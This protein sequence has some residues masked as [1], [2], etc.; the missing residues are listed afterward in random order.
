MEDN[1][2]LKVFVSYCHKDSKYLDDFIKHVRPLCDKKYIELWY[3][4]NIKAGEKFQEKI[5]SNSKNADIVVLLVSVNFLSSNACLIEKKAAIKDDKTI[6]PIIISSCAWKDDDD[7]LKLLAIPKDGKPITE[8]KNKDQGWQ[9]VYQ[10]F[11]EIIELHYEIKQIK[12]SNSFIK[13]LNNTELFSQAHSSKTEIFVSDIFVEPLLIKYDTTKNGNEKIDNI[14]KLVRELIDNKQIIITGDGQSGKTTI[15]KMLFNIL[16]EKNLIPLFIID[17]E[18]QYNGLITN[19]IKKAFQE[20]YCNEK[21]VKFE[22]IPKKFFALILDNFHFAKNGKKIIEDMS[23]YTYKVLIAD[24]ICNLNEISNFNNYIEYKIQEFS[25][26]LRNEL[27][28]KWIYVD[29]SANIDFHGNDGYKELDDKM[30]LVDRT[31]GKTIASGIMPSYPFFILSVLAMHESGKPLASEITSQGYCYQALIYAYLRKCGVKNDDIDTYINFLSEIA[32][33]MFKNNQSYLIPDDFN[34]N[35]I[36]EYRKKYNLTIALKELLYNLNLAKI[37]YKNNFGNYTFCYEYIYYFFVAKYFSDHI[38]SCKEDI[39]VIIE[40]LHDDKNAYILIFIIHHTKD[41]YILDKLLLNSI[42]LFKECNASTLSKSE[43]SFFD[44]EI[45]YIMDISSFPSSSGPEKERANKLQQQE[46]TE[47]EESTKEDSKNKSTETF[48]KS[49]KTVEVMGQ[50]VKNRSGSLEK[51]KIEQIIREGMNVYLRIL[52]Y[53]MPLIKESKQQNEIILYIQNSIKII[54]KQRGYA[55]NSQDME[56]L[57]KR[58]FWNLIFLRIYSIINKAIRSL[59]SDKNRSIIIE[60]CNN[61]NTPA[62]DMIR[63]GI[64]M[65][66]CKNLRL[67]EMPSKEHDS[68]YSKIALRILKYFVVEYCLMHKINYKDKQKICK[69]FDIR[70]ACL[71]PHKQ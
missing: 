48:K 65:W 40:N 66:H 64:L 61:E 54:N 16:K 20:Q 62:F 55:M 63:H 6:V 17:N 44:K 69:K 7:L 52:S 23:E 24:D 68:D 21:N 53:L 13:F 26:T 50:I 67:E 25:A 22:N 70:Q 42:S 8:F 45:D 29:K 59:G 51:T 19:K 56:E 18:N 57:A 37:F 9:N 33:Y 47:A 1:A 15:C 2:N 30:E 49:F 58:I 32:F 38:E 14:N 5:E 28:K 41:N 35:F 34:D 39:N 31:L 10:Y 3:D 60:I 4:K 71:L 43:L 36:I 46:E 12:I 11:M 27:I